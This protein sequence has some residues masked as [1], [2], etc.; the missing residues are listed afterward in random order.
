MSNQLAEILD[1]TEERFLKI[2]PKAINYDAEKGF[3]IQL[4]KNNDYLMKAANSSPSSLQQA[5]TNVAA[6]GLSLN[7]AEKLSYLIPRNIKTGEGRWETRIYLEPSYMGLIRLATNS[8]SIEWIQAKVVCESDDF[9]DNGVG[10]K[11]THKFNAFAKADARGEVVGAY[12]VAKTHKGDYLT[13]TMTLERLHEIRGRSETYKK[14]KSGTWVTDFE[15]MAK[16][17]VIRLLFKTLPRTDENAR[18]SLA[19][20]MSN[21]NEGF[22]AIV[23]NPE[24]GNYTSDQKEYFDGL[25]EGNQAFSMFVLLKTLDHSIISGLYSS[26]ERGSK[27]KYRDIIMKLDANGRDVAD[28]YV[29]TLTEAS[30][31]ANDEAIQEAVAELSDDELTVIKT[32]LDAETLGA[33][34]LVIQQGG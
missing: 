21:A 31:S 29:A 14:Y 26:F 24:T 34:E 23:N 28:E 11:P 27:G 13:A 12:A 16:K 25:I 18:M 2:A 20:D 17:A 7:P 3:A 1:L 30:A 22:E 6:I 15:E 19:V 9:V 5:I 8:G 10:E 32:M 4:L 33:V